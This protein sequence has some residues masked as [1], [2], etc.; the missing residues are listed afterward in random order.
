MQEKKE[1][2]EPL[3]SLRCKVINQKLYLNVLRL[4]LRRSN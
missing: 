1:C 3:K 4:R 2:G